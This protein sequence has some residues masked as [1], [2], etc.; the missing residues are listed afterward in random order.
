MDRLRQAIL[1]VQRRGGSVALLFIDL[2]NFKQINDTL[3]HDCGDIVLRQA[4]LRLL[5]CLRDCDTAAR[6]GGD[7][8]LII[9]SELEGK[10]EVIPIIE[11]ILQ[12]FALPFSLEGKDL[13]ATTSIGVSLCPQNGIDPAHLL[14]C[15]D[16]AMYVAKNNGKNSYS[17]CE[18]EE[19]S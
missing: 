16:S 11:R 2:D 12:T 15:S 13:L 3:G 14:K 18:S 6:F 1:Q 10:N 7:E 5:D 17:F 8:F 9:L 4:A 19:L